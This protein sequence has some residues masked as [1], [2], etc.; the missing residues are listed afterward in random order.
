MQIFG[1]LEKQIPVGTVFF[2]EQTGNFFKQDSI[3]WCLIEFTGKYSFN[4]IAG[5]IGSKWFRSVFSLHSICFIFRFTFNNFKFLLNQIAEPVV[6]SA[7]VSTGN[8]LLRTW[9]LTLIK[10]LE[11]TSGS[12]L[13]LLFRLISANIDILL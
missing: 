10:Y 2:V 7:I 8:R 13:I 5:C 4:F 1:C 11:T 3:V 6:T 12:L 9:L